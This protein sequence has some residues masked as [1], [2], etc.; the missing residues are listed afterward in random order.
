MQMSPPACQQVLQRSSD[1]FENTGVHWR[2]NRM[3][4][5]QPGS[6]Q[7]NT[8]D[9]RSTPPSQWWQT[10]SRACLPTHSLHKPAA[11]WPGETHASHHNAK[12]LCDAPCLCRFSE[13]C[14]Q[15]LAPA[16]RFTALQVSQERARWQGRQRPFGPTSC[17]F[18]QTTQT[19]LRLFVFSACSSGNCC[20]KHGLQYPRRPG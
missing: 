18:P 13:Q 3:R 12:R 7:L 19:F 20:W 17:T 16:S 11:I 14:S 5:P 10:P 15:I 1:A 4:T 8:C 6:L 2:Q 9:E